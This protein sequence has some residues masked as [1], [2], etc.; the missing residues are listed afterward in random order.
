M[1]LVMT[2]DRVPPRWAEKKGIPLCGETFCGDASDGLRIALINNMPDPALED[3]EVQFFDLLDA[4]AGDI[5]VFVTMFSLSEVARG[6]RARAHISCHYSPIS[7]IFGAKFDGAIITG[8]EP[9]HRNM[10]DEPYWRSL[11]QVLDWAETGTTSSILSCLAAHASVLHS[12][13]IER[14]P[15]GD[16]QF[17]VFEYKRHADHPLIAGAVAPSRFP[18]SRWNEVRDYA[19][20]ARGYEILDKSPDAGVNLFVKRKQRSLFVHFQGHPE[21]FTRTLLKEYRRD[22]RRYLTRER[23]T[24]PTEPRGYF[25]NE[26]IKLLNEFRKNAEANR[27]E[28][29]M[30]IF[31]EAAVGETLQNTWHDSAVGIYRNWLDILSLGKSG[32]VA[33]A[34][35]VAT[36]ANTAGPT[37]LAL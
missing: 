30:D 25:D 21:Y 28:D 16:K 27:Q 1:P 13:N 29:L 32:R 2:G 11:T 35:T 17:G 37:P 15:L 34:S 31:P 10:R 8:T 4:A 36:R 33:A 6:D 24:Y 5:P 18:H 20:V 23:E 7:K 9:K 19:L 12:D 22:V 14:N 3:T 26:A